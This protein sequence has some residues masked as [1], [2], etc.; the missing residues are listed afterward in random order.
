MLLSVWAFDSTDL[1]MPVY[2]MIFYSYLRKKRHQFFKVTF[3]R[4]LSI[5][6]V[7]WQW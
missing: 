3:V 2:K 6:D 4:T 7:Y 5:A 1:H